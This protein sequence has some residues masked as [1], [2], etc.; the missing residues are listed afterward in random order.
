M[1]IFENMSRTPG[2]H[3]FTIYCIALRFLRLHSVKRR[4]NSP[5]WPTRP[6]Q[7]GTP[8][9]FNFRQTFPC[10][11]T[12]TLSLPP[13]MILHSPPPPTLP[14]SI[15][16]RAASSRSMTSNYSRAIA[17]ATALKIQASCARNGKTNSNATI[18]ASGAMSNTC[19]RGR[20][21][22]GTSAPCTSAI[23][24][25]Q[26]ATPWRRSTPSWAC[27]RRSDRRCCLGIRSSTRARR[28]SGLGSIRFA[29]GR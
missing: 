24:S 10:E 6:V 3:V 29:S 15:Q 11:R 2:L 7:A 16:M 13:A 12:S 17:R 26:Q 8:M 20:T 9:A 22:I 4:N 14:S 21:R 28:R 5:R 18:T 19:P 27:C 1:A 23:T 25:R